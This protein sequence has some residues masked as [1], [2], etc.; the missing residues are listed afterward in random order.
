MRDHET[1]Y[2]LGECIDCLK[3]GHTTATANSIYFRFA[4]EKLCLVCAQFKYNPEIA[5]RAEYH[6]ATMIKKRFGNHP[7]VR[8]I[9]FDQVDPDPDRCSRRRPDIRILTHTSGDGILECDENGHKP[10]M[11]SMKEIQNSWTELQATKSSFV[12]RRIQEDSRLSEIVTTGTI[13]KTMV[14]RL[15]VDRYCSD[16]GLILS[17]K[18][19]LHGDEVVTVDI[20]TARETRFNLVCDEIQ[21]WLDGKLDLVDRPFISVVYFYYDGP[22]RQESLVPTDGDEY[23][24]WITELSTHV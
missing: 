19:I 1:Y 13:D 21:T 11:C 14:W 10:Y 8:S 9:L 22:L 5:Y 17:S 7:N 3:A 16:E 12:R 23:K 4:E 18:Q 6:L 15:N 2:H 20:A 24:Q